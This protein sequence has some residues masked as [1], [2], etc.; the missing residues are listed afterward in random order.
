MAYF[1]TMALGGMGGV[2]VP[3]AVLTAILTRWTWAAPVFYLLVV[4][5]SAWGVVIS[6]CREAGGESGCRG[7]RAAGWVAFALLVVNVPLL[8]FQV[9]F[10]VSD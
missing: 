1:L 6:L 3:A 2:R 8:L 5:G 9:H 10:L 4:G 7:T